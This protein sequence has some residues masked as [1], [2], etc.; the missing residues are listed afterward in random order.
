MATD[1][2]AAAPDRN[3]LA[4]Q[5]TQLANERTLLAY[6]RTAI[7]LG[8]TGATIIELYSNKVIAVVLGSLLLAAAL[9][10]AV[11]GTHRFRVRKRQLNTESDAGMA[12]S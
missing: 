2:V 1:K 9:T 12:R 5:R 11:F 7:M 8:V 6:A 10:V 3:Q 4:L